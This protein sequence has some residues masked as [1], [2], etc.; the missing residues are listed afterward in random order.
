MS[1]RLR[2]FEL[3]LSYTLNNYEGFTYTFMCK[4]LP[5]DLPK[6]VSCSSPFYESFLLLFHLPKEIFHIL[7]NESTSLILKV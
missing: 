1:Q 3:D 5:K 4:S 2:R 7:Y 6:I